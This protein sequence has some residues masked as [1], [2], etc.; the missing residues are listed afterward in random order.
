M[1]TKAPIK[2]IVFL[3]EIYPRFEI[4]TYRIKLFTEL[5]KTGTQFPPLRVVKE[6][7]YY[8]LLD[9]KHRLEARKEIG[10]STVEVKL[11][12]L[13]KKYWKLAAAR[14]N[15]QSAKPLS[16]DEL[17]K[18]I[19]DAWESGI[20]NAT[21][22]AQ[23][24][25]QACTA[26]YIRKIIKPLRDKDREERNER[27][28]TL[29]K[30]GLSQREIADELNVSL[31]TV[32][33]VLHCSETEQVPFLNTPESALSSPPT[34]DKLLGN[35]IS[36]Q[37]NTDDK[38]DFSS[39][40]EHTGEEKFLSCVP[41]IEKAWGKKLT[42]EQA[43]TIQTLELVKRCNEDLLTIAKKTGESLLWV[44]N[45]VIAAISLSLNK[46]DE[47][48]NITNKTAKT[49]QLQIERVQIIRE[50]LLLQMMLSPL[51]DRLPD[52]VRKNLGA[53]EVKLIADLAAIPVSD[54]NYLLKGEQSPAFPR[55]LRKDMFLKIID[56][57]RE[58]RKFFKDLSTKMKNGAFIEE[59]FAK[60]LKEYNKVRTAINQLD[61]EL[62]KYKRAY[63]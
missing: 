39:S 7:D 54:L 55:Q 12:N 62:V 23:Q 37:L 4:D 36:R 22:I 38:P 63:F 2:D 50:A 46:K 43:H 33:N 32:N 1:E 52:W 8:V 18:V 3:K 14:F 30:Q 44:K 40:E 45:T 21:E 24:I 60:F 59:S 35:D 9:G 5:M 16:G 41:D 58:T 26:R 57:L 19:V 29:K 47:Q 61:D 11:Y 49:L 42:P 6:N 13:P 25:G 56:Q 28:R 48:E 34:Y 15:V 53:K 17:K 20:K 10:E 51:S 27:I 31:G